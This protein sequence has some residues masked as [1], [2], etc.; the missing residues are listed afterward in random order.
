MINMDEHG[1]TWIN[2]DEHGGWDTSGTLTWRL[3]RRTGWN[4]G[5][6]RE[7]PLVDAGH[8]VLLCSNNV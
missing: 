1:W 3:C 4:L 7:G 2:M 8:G 6:S 5:V